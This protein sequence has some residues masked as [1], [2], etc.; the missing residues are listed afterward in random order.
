M[1][2][3][4][5]SLPLRDCEPV[6]DDTPQRVHPIAPANLFAFFIGSPA[7]GDA[8]FVY[9]PLVTGHLDGDFWLTTEPIL[10]KRK[11]VEYLATKG[12]IARLHIGQVD[13]SDGIAQQGEHKVTDPMPKIEAAPLRAGH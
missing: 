12:L 11:R 8:Y 7:V 3:K 2:F 13:V 4:N 6:L 9:T 1:R 5:R 10:L